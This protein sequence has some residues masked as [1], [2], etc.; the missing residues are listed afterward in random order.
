[1]VRPVMVKMYC[2]MV[3]LLDEDPLEKGRGIACRGRESGACSPAPKSNSP[4]VFLDQEVEGLFPLVGAKRARGGPIEQAGI[5]ESGG[6]S[7]RQR[8]L[9]P[10]PVGGYPVGALACASGG[11]PGIG[12]LGGQRPRLYP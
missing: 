9:S 5:R 6:G 4:A 2:A 1:M 12:G 7:A 11:T 8:A 10:R 3:S